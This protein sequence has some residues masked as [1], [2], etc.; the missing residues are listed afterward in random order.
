[1]K[2]FLVVIVLSVSQQLSANK[3]DSLT[4]DEDVLTF[5]GT[6]DKEFAATTPRKAGFLSMDS[7]V[8]RFKCYLLPDITQLKNW[9]KVDFDMDGRTDLLTMIHWISISEYSTDAVVIYVTLD[10]GNNSFRTI[11]LSTGILPRCQFAKPIFF[12]GN[13]GLLFYH[14]EYA[15]TKGAVNILDLESFR[16]KDTLIYKDGRFI[17][18]NNRPSPKNVKFIEFR[19]SQCYGTCPVFGMRINNDRKAVYH[20]IKYNPT[21]GK[22]KATIEEHEFQEIMRLV[23]YLKIDE[24]KDEYRVDWT[25][26]QTGFLKIHYEDGSIKQIQDYGLI[27]SFGLRGLYKLLFD[28]RENQQWKR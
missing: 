13:A 1:M 14:D 28:L 25:D 2:K 7:L 17:E 19:T 18:F 27:G 15:L 23:G 24:L 10:L 22:L 6:V 21:E 16:K 4:T 26:D 5:L 20:A 11:R 12:H 9:D 8:A 3:I